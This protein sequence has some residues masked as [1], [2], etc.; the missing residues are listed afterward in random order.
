M[1]YNSTTGIITA[2]VSIYDL[3][4]A[5][6]AT[7]R[8]TNTSTSEVES[9]SSD[10][11][12][13]LAGA[14]VGDT[15]PSTDGHGT[16]SVIS[17]VAV[18]MWAKFKPVRSYQSGLLDTVSQLI[19]GVWNNALSS[20][21][22]RD[23]VNAAGLRIGYGINPIRR[24]G[25][26]GVG[27]NPLTALLQ[28][29]Q[30]GS[31]WTYTKPNG[32]DIGGSTYPY[33]LLDFHQY[34]HKAPQPLGSI[35]APSSLILTTGEAW[36][37]DVAMMR[38]QDDSEPI[39]DRDYVTPEDI[40]KQLWVDENDN[41]VCY[42]GF[43]LMKSNGDPAIWVTGN[44][45]Y[46]VGNNGGRLSE[47]TYTV[48]PFY[49]NRLLPQDESLGNLNPGPSTIPSGT[50]FATVPNVECP[51]LVI[52]NGLV[53]RDDA[54]WSVKAVLQS[55]VCKVTAKAD[56]T[57]LQVTGGTVLFDGGKY[58]QVV[59]Y[60]CKEGTT[61]GVGLPDANDILDSRSFYSQQNLFE[62]QG[63]SS[64]ESK[65]VGG[66]QQ[67]FYINEEKC[68]VFVYAGNGSQYDTGMTARA[69]GDAMISSGTIVPDNEPLVTI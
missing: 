64:G 30:A 37:I 54:R 32:T 69:Q 50:A 35:S 63:G 20:Q 5:V 45:Y 9:V 1:A 21:W 10:D 53:H 29:Y 34:N 23:T 65:T 27:D 66:A 44:R 22:W 11:L 39:A 41:P 57:P 18:N 56:A 3:M 4:Q 49:T 47:G 19:N 28:A 42:F 6:P 15:I 13:V 51:Q 7:L 14:S 61:V 48:M 60:V 59:I 8:R 43:A 26:G 16:W 62:V 24:T 67:N 31:Q 58:P 17:R 38:N 33:R 68:R 52:P 2:P 12:G 46:G 55:G 25:G 40:L 36:S